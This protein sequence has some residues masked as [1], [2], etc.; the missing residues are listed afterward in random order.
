MIEGSLVEFDLD[1]VTA[2]FNKPSRV[3]VFSAL[4]AGGLYVLSWERTCP[5]T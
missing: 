2:Q 3:P 5:T 1:V 4:D